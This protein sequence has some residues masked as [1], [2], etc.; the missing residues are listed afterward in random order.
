MPTDKKRVN[1]TLP[2]P[3]YERILAYKTKNGITSDAS[4]CLQLITRQ[5]EAMEQGE[6]MLQAASKFSLDELQQL[7]TMGFNLIK[8]AAEKNN[9]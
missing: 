1:L 7:S 6:L 9:L 8:E 5:L 3:V 4:A 2:D